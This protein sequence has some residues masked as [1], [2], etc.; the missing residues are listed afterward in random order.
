[1]K[2]V[3]IKKFSC[4]KNLKHMLFVVSILMASLQIVAQQATGSFILMD[5]GMEAQTA[6]QLPNTTSSSIPS[7]VWNR[8]SA[9]GSVTIRNIVATG[10]RTGNKFLQ[11]NN[12]STTGSTNVVSPSVASGAVV[13]GS[14]YIIQF[15]YRATD[16]TTLPN[17]QISVGASSAS[18]TGVTNTNYIPNATTNNAA[19]LKSVTPVIA[20]GSS[21]GNGY[22]VFRIASFATTNSAGIDIDDWVMYAGTT[23]DITPPN[24]AGLVNVASPTAS[25]L[26]VSWGASTNVDG[27]GYIVVRYTTNPLGQP[28]PNTN[29]IY[30][31][32]NSIGT[33]TV[34]YS[35]TGTSFTNNFLTANTNYFYRVY[36]V[37]KAFNYSASSL[38]TGSTNNTI[39][40][41]KYFIDATNGNDA[42][43]GNSI[44]TAWKSIAKV[45]STTFA[46]GDSI[47][48]KSGE[49]WSG[50][51]LWPKG[52]GTIG[53][54]IV[55]SKYGV[56]NLP[57]I[58]AHTL[59]SPN[60]NGVY[61]FN[62]QYFTI[63]DLEI[64]NNYASTNT[65][66]AIKKGVY[67][68]ATNFGT[69]RGITLKNLVIHDV[70]GTYD[71]NNE[72]GGIFCNI[73]GTTTITKFDSLIIDNC[74]VYNVDKIGISN[75]STW[76]G[77]DAIGDYGATPWRPSTNYIVRNCRV[78][79]SGGNSL[80][81]R[82][83]Q[84]PLIE[85][86]IFWKSS[87]RYSGNSMFTF[88]CDDALV[89]YNEAAFNVYNANDVDASGFDGDYRCKRTIFQYNY[90]H[91]NDGGAFV[92][93]CQPDGVPGRFNDGN[94][95]RYNISQN[96]GKFNGGIN[97]EGQIFSITGQSTNT[98]IYNNVIFSSS[99]FNYAI[100]HR[101]WGDAGTVWPDNTK[102]Y[103]NIFYFNKSNATFAFQSSSNNLLNNNV[104]YYAPPFSGSNPLDA[105]VLTSN[106][107]FVNPGTGANGL[108]TVDGYKLQNTSPCINSGVLL[109]GHATKDF[110]GNTVPN[111][112]GQNPDRGAFE[113]NSV[114]PVTLL[115]FKGSIL[116][117]QNNLSWVTTTE[118]NNAGFQIQHSGDG[119]VFTDIAFVATKTASGNSVGN[120]SYSFNHRYTI[121]GKNYYRLKQIDKDGKQS[122]SVIVVLQNTK[123]NV[124]SM[125]VYPNP[126]VGKKMSLLINHLPAGK[127]EVTIID[128]SGKTVFNSFVQHDGNNLLPITVSNILQKGNYYLRLFNSIISLNT[129]LQIQ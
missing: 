1:M 89:Q 75:N 118:I 120:I 39:A 53:R 108:N 16:L 45:N 93:V 117:S 54:P 104:F 49:I 127:Y 42:N 9:T 124:V 25:T 80:I 12:T 116:G 88:N 13:G 91:D 24:V 20:A 18:G 36:T 66:T 102:Y 114:L 62:Q 58:N 33:G 68:L 78:D 87:K 99:D 67:V 34:V 79:S 123:N 11:I 100:V 105:Q 85:N 109:S 27:G 38:A 98:T 95:L 52:S 110:W 125:S 28:D 37:D 61:L 14:S 2:M 10:G 74:K 29:G 71:S 23:E 77:R 70:L 31:I 55:V 48:F 59:S 15:F 97:N 26:N 81:V 115:S 84:S 96:D 19:W 73:T 8:S 4:Y 94:V 107:L 44:A 5:G 111:V 3:K 32:G 64:T 50:S 46:P 112:V 43:D 113:A 128:V 30:S 41:I 21:V 106:P 129:N 82:D 92:V 76:D 72:S 83:A 56:G 7:S 90:S 69:V 101:R 121:V 103:N 40:V 63:A 51:M 47:L 22:C 126:F 6:G 35:G 65:D 122:F 17:A 86:N 119:V 57:L 60:E